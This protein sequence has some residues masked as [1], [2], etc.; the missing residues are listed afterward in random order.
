MT[1]DR[2]IVL[3]A[4][5]AGLAAAYRLSR[6]GYPVT[7]L[8]K[9]KQVGGLSKT[10]EYKDCYFDIGGHRFFTRIDEVMQLWIELL[11][12]KLKITPRLSRIFYQ[13]KFF[14]YPI[15]PL[16]A[17]LK[18]GLLESVLVGLS[19]VR[20]KLFPQPRIR[21]FEEWVSQQFGRRLFRIFFK[22]Y[23]EKV[24]GV[25][26]D[27]ISAAW[28]AQRIKDLSLK[29]LIKSALG[30]SRSKKIRTLI[31]E[32][33]YP[34]RGPGMMY[35]A[36]AEGIEIKGGEME[37]GSD[38]IKIK[39]DNTG[40]ISVQVKTDGGNKTWAGKYFLSSISVTECLQKLDPPP[41]PE[42]LGAAG[43]LSFRAH[44]AVNLL[45]DQK[46]IFRD[47]WLYIHS[48]ELG[49]GRIQ[50]YKNWSSRMVCNQDITT[51]GIE[52]F[53]DEGDE[54]WN[55]ADEDLIALAKKELAATNLVST[56]R[57][58]D[59]F[60]KRSANAYPVYKI[61]YQ[62]KLEVVKSYLNQFQNLQCIGR[63]GQY[64]YNNMDHSILSGILAAKNI[65][66]PEKKQ[67][68]WHT[69]VEDKYIEY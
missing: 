38:V 56:D 52:Y 54:L 68:V 61:G 26:C 32:F 8:E 29:S 66:K 24:W 11:E 47:N 51:L 9:E 62:D 37:V 7:V 18:L 30:G 50:N 33:H 44:V 42:V 53:C 4:G 43:F 12:D 1:K 36:L 35:S 25:P 10:Y 48:P 31:P 23:T 55:T 45:I 65:I 20:I 28:A 13:G 58:F 5:P 16:K 21:T 34:E 40:I 63:S 27:Q 49:M 67:D 46:E 39:R 2:T 59:G 19:F 41:P 60:V 15:K 6:E 22:T 14:D 57:V 69:K 3:G 64:Q 17:L